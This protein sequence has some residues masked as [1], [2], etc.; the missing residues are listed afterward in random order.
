VAG[1]TSNISPLPFTPWIEVT[2]S[3]LLVQ[4]PLLSD[5]FKMKNIMDKPVQWF[6]KDFPSQIVSLHGHA[7]EGILE[8]NVWSEQLLVRGHWHQI[9]AQ[10]TKEHVF[11][12]VG[13]YGNSSTQEKMKVITD[14]PNDLKK[15][16]FN[17]IKRPSPR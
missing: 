17:G 4:Q 1:K 8:P 11:F 9:I 10:T 2:K 14:D 12:I 13:R 16:F 6:F 3:I 5:E 7:M 15:W